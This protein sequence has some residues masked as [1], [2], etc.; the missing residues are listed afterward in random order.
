[1]RETPLR[2]LVVPHEASTATLERIEWV[3]RW[4]ESLARGRLTIGL[5]TAPDAGLPP[6]DRLALAGPYSSAR[7]ALAR[8]AGARYPQGLPLLFIGMRGT[9]PHSWTLPG[10]Q[11]YAAVAEDASKTVI[12]HE[13]G[14]L[15]FGFP[16]LAFSPDSGAVC[17]MGRLPKCAIDEPPPEPCAALQVERGWQDAAPLVAGLDPALL[18]QNRAYGW[19][20]LVVTR[21]RDRLLAFSR[22]GRRQPHIALRHAI[23][24]APQSRCALALISRAGAVSLTATRLRLAHEAHE[25]SLQLASDCH[26]AKATERRSL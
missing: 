10:G 18:A 16:D 21:Q 15:L 19:A 20:G 17:L 9:R 13:L 26:S 2:L 7:A 4:F 8:C 1:M 22:G 25:G 11:P 3:A 6:E 23:D 12:A 14:H 24:I 5:E